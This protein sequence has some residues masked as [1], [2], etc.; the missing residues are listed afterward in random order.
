MAKK[1][2][3]DLDL[4]FQS[5]PSTGDIAKK[6]DDEAIKR[7]VRNIVF[8]NTYDRPFHPEMASGVRALLFENVTPV[9]AQLIA[10][11]IKDA[12]VAF[13]P[14]VELIDVAVDPSLDNNHYG[15]TILFRLKNTQRQQN[16]NLVLQRIR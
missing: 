6:V 15:V 11:R 5:H 16:L 10:N 2:F 1:R 13:E 14:R 7:S 3:I 4:D 12:I 8:T 9:I